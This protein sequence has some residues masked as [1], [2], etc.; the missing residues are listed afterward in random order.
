MG[1][2]FGWTGWEEKQLENFCDE[3]EP[4][5]IQFYFNQQC[6]IQSVMNNY[7]R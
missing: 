1:P 5:E 4:G 2:E 7:L 6:K 3:F